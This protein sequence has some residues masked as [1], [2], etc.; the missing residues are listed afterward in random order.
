MGSTVV[1]V[2]VVVLLLLVED[3]RVSLTEV[4]LTPSEF[5]SYQVSENATLTFCL[6]ELRVKLRSN[7]LT[8]EQDYC[9][10]KKI[11]KN[12]QIHK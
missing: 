9:R 10:N 5:D 8:K 1:V 4:A 12:K 3:V 11:K 2:V 6:K 7:K